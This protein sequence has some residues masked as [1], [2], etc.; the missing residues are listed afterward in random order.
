MDGR[1]SLPAD[2]GSPGCP[3]LCFSGTRFTVCSH[4]DQRLERFVDAML[5]PGLGDRLELDVGRVATLGCVVRLDGAHLGQVE[6]R[7]TLLREREKR[8]I[9]QARSAASL[10]PRTVRISVAFE[11]RASAGKCGVISPTV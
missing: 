5:A 11:L 6:R 10:K 2:R 7:A 1:R 4:L 3:G 9:A 8:G